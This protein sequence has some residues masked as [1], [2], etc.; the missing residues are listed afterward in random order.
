MESHRQEQGF[1]TSQLIGRVGE[2][3]DHHSWASRD[4][5]TIDCLAVGC[6]YNRDKECMVPSKCEISETG[7]CK[8]FEMKPLP[9]VLDGD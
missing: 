4:Y 8:G 6:R 5:L 9:K 1:H 3:S 7:A 2:R